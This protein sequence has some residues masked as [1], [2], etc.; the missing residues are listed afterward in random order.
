MLVAYDANC[1]HLYTNYKRKE[2]KNM[3]DFTGGEVF[4]ALFIDNSTWSI[5]WCCCPTHCLIYM[6]LANCS[7]ISSDPSV[8]HD[9][10]ENRLS[11]EIKL[12]I[13]CNSWQLVGSTFRMRITHGI[14]IVFDKC[15]Q[16]VDNRNVYWLSICL[17]FAYPSNYESVRT[18]LLPEIWIHIQEKYRYYILLRVDEFTSIFYLI[19]LNSVISHYCRISD[20]VHIELFV[21]CTTDAAKCI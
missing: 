10:I 11:L 15:F 12:I 18:L 9:K 5:T 8:F 17:C 6:I 7:W 13:Y 14:S 19:Q 4:V 1:V 2:V 3:K 21:H 20:L 16:I